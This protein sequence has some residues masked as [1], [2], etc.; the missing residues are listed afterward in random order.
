MTV[1]QLTAVRVAARSVADKP[2]AHVFD[3]FRIYNGPFKRYIIPLM[4]RGLA[5]KVLPTRRG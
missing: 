4:L 2:G 1:Q 3:D 5:A